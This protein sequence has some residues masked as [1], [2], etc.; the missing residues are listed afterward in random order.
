MPRFLVLLLLTFAGPAQAVPPGYDLDELR[1]RTAAFL[2]SLA[3][4]YPAVAGVAG[5]ASLPT[6]LGAHDTL[7]QAEDAYRRGDPAR[8]ARLLQPAVSFRRR[9]NEP[10]VIDL[11]LR[12][13]LA[14]GR[15]AE[16]ADWLIAQKSADIQTPFTRFNLAVAL[17]R[18]G[19]EPE[20]VTLL[21]RVGRLRARD[22]ESRALRD[23]ANLALGW[24]FLGRELGGNAKAAF[25]QV[26]LQGLQSNAALLG[27][28]WAELAPQGKR[29]YRDFVGD[30]ASPF[31]NRDLSPGMARALAER[32]LLEPELATL[33]TPDRLL[34]Y[35]MA[36]LSSGEKTALG[37]AAAFWQ[38]LHGR[39]R[40]DPFVW[41]AWIALPYVLEKAGAYEPA[42]AHYREAIGRLEALE[43]EMAHAAAQG[44]RLTAAVL[45]DL[46]R[47]YLADGQQ[48]LLLPVSPASAEWAATWIARREAQVLLQDLGEA[49]DYRERLEDLAAPLAGDTALGRERQELMRLWSEYAQRRERQFDA[50]LR[51]QLELRQAL[52]RRYRQSAHIALARLL[53]PDVVQ[54]APADGEPEPDLWQRLRSYLMGS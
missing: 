20:A 44:E 49:R 33:V 2:Q 31:G 9:V 17:M 27:I 47:R 18:A 4:Q 53:D 13:L 29:I 25:R 8:A 45:S 34:P 50:M 11:Y 10:A 54:P 36:R 6:P 12:V 1:T 41:E 28:G 35:P 14:Q 15:G 24:H 19:K 30:E 7:A 38:A 37:R 42:I 40:H 39:D 21:Y 46:Q 32:R 48:A 22:E 51:G 23:Q 52:L 5:A 26:R 43:A 3:G 16:A